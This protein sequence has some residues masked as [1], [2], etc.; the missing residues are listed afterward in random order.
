MYFSLFLGF[1]QKLVKKW[2]FFGPPK[3]VQKNGLFLGGPQILAL[4]PFLSHFFHVLKKDA[5]FRSI[6][7]NCGKKW[8]KNGCFFRVFASVCFVNSILS[9]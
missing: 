8:L 2:S 4:T 6:L 9:D 7:E 3:K 5:D 1:W